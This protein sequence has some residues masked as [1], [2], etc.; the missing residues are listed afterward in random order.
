MSALAASN[1]SDHTPQDIRW[2]DGR[3][4]AR[5]WAITRAQPIASLVVSGGLWGFTR[6]VAPP[7][8]LIGKRLIITAGG[9]H[10]PFN[11]A[12]ASGWAAVADYCGQQV[13]PAEI[14]S[15]REKLFREAVKTLPVSQS[16]GA[17]RLAAAF[18]IGNV[19]GDTVYADVR[20]PGAYSA[21]RQMG[22]WREFDQR[23]LPR[24]EKL[25]RGRWMWC[26]DAHHEFDLDHRVLV[27]GYSG[28]WDYVLGLELRGA[29]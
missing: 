26:F 11:Q 9:D 17:V 19:I 28:I 23:D 5:N 7:A 27:K 21:P 8:P 13:S 6:S 25:E 18:Q 16:V 20:A 14:P 24:L 22:I 15:G 10:H 4:P 12:G 29:L 1:S 3:D 2:M